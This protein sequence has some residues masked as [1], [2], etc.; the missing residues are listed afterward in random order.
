MSSTH[1]DIYTLHR[2]FFL[3]FESKMSRPTRQRISVEDKLRLV[4]AHRNL[5]DYQLLADQLGINRST[6]RSIVS[7]AM[8]QDDPELI[9]NKPRGGPRRIKVDDEMREVVEEILGGNPAIT[10]RDLN[11][12]V[13][14]RLPHKPHITEA[15]LGRVC[16]GMFFTLKKLEAAPIDRNREDVKEE[17]LSYATWFLEVANSSPRIVYIDES[18]FNVWTQRTRGRARIGQRAVRTVH[19]QRGENLTLI[20]AVSPQNGVEKHSFHVGGTTAAKFR[21][22]FASL[23]DAVGQQTHCI[24]VLDNAPCHR[25]IE[26]TSA[27]HVVRFLPAYSPMLTPVENAFS[28]WKWTV[29][30]RLSDP[31]VQATFSDPV[32]AREQGM[33]L[34]QWRRHKLQQFGEEGIPVVTASK[35]ANWQTHCMSFFPRCFAKEDIL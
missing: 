34:G 9:V 8:R 14:R 2:L 4:R 29:K 11:A 28:A 30:N 5:E 15:H 22:F 16:R 23:E 17:R 31:Q 10:L 1:H 24:F 7:T 27:N 33:N 35:V 13:R 20:L 19:G 25:A 3:C 21:E 12:E 26:P 32:A 6:A 18:G